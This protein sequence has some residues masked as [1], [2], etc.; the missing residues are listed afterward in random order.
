MEK[1]SIIIQMELNMKETG[2][3]TAKLA[4]VY[5]F[6]RI[7]SSIKGSSRIPKNVASENT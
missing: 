1:V 7:K 2:I 3:I 4:K 6:T 5:L